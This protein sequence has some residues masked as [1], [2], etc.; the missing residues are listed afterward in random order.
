M[1]DGHRQL[2]PLRLRTRA[3]SNCTYR[4]RNHRGSGTFESMPPVS[5]G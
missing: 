2:V 5:P 1:A 4:H 3:R